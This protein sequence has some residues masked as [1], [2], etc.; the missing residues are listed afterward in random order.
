[1]AE[2]ALERVAATDY[3]AIVSD[4]KLPGMDG[5]TLMQR[6]LELRPTTPTLLITGHADRDIRVRAMNAGAYAF[7]RKAD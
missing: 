1:M 2:T 4:I 3:D 5:L 6:V 7:Y